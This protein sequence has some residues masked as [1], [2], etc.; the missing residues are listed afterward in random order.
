MADMF[1]NCNSFTKPASMK[2]LKK[3][4]GSYAMKGMYTTC[5]TLKDFPFQFSSLEGP[6]PDY[7]FKDMF[8]ICH[9][10]ST[11]LSALPTGA[12]GAH[13]F[14][15]AFYY[16]NIN[17]TSKKAPECPSMEIGEAGYKNMFDSIQTFEKPMDILPATKLSTKS[18]CNMFSRCKYLKDA[19]VI[20]Y[21]GTVPEL[22]Y[23]WMFEECNRLTGE[24][25]ISAT[26]L[27]TKSL[28]GMFVNTGSQSSS[29]WK[30]IKVAFTDWNSAEY[31]TGSGTNYSWFQ[32]NFP[33]TSAQTFTC[34]A[35]LDTD[36]ITRGNFTIPENW[37]I[38]KY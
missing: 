9:S 29:K 36:T 35:A 20:K 10:L 14:E 4:T 12:I 22:A 23:A 19:P 24:V 13:A 37:T 25:V 7:A 33:N 21:S 6:I 5:T 30:G 27:G 17:K 18:Y 8:A 31:A 1:H 3:V 2:N 11:E 28:E 32:Q 15:N 34:P 38:V 16:T 26:A